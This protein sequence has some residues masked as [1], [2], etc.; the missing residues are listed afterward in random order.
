MSLSKSN[1]WYSNNC[2]QLLKRAVP[3]NLMK[4]RECYQVLNI[5]VD[6]KPLRDTT[7]STVLSTFSL[8]H[9]KLY[10]KQYNSIVSLGALQV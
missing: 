10:E 2:L 8:Y 3:L 7:T 4:S 1:C 9:H 5:S 6:C